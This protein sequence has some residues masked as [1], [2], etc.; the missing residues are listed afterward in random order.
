MSAAAPTA[1]VSY[2]RFALLV[3]A[4]AALLRLLHLAAAMRSPITFNPGPDEDFYLRF[5]GQVA[6]GAPLPIDFLFMDPLYG[7]LAGAL[8]ALA[9][10]SVFALYALQAAVDTLTVYMLYRCGVALSA[11]RA[12][13]V[14][15]A[16]YALSATAILF[17]A[18][19]LKPTWVAAFVVGWTWLALGCLRGASPRRWLM[20]GLLCGLGIALRSNLLLLGAFALAVLP[21]LASSGRTGVRPLAVRTAALGAGLA[22]VLVVLAFNNSRAGLGWTPLP[23]NGGIVLHHLYNVDNPQARSTYPDFVAYRHPLDIWR[24]YRDEAHR[25]LQRA[26]PP[27]EVSAYWRGEALAYIRA[28]PAQFVRNAVRKLGEFIAWPEVP[29]N[30]ILRQE[31]RY[32]AVLAALPSPFGWLLALGVPGLLLLARSDWRAAAVVAAPLLVCAATVMVFFAESR[33]RFHA[34]P[35]LA[36][37]GG[38]LVDRA[39]AWLV[40]RRWREPAIYATV[41]A[42]TGA[43][44][45]VLAHGQAPVHR[46]EASREAWGFARMGDTDRAGALARQAL[47]AGESD[48]AL[49]ELLGFLAARGGQHR[50]A[51]G[52]YAAALALRPDGHATYHSLALSLAALDDTA[53]ALAAIDIALAY[54]DQP[55]YRQL[56]SELQARL[57][58]PGLDPAE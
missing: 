49:H 15:A 35:S 4:A 26:A 53:A 23:F 38:V 44:S 27:A 28:E 51:V 57:A 13:L 41:A 24:G 48:P 56:R 20:L 6:Q 58:A 19:A 30:R 40:A 34:V 42:A 50:E 33:F 11:P 32:S 16:L 39:W 29:N 14:A 21:A 43:L 55:E 7:Y 52:H 31:Q 10:S 22:L 1:A 3:T 47:A 46:N 17:T 9:G 2:G 54:A 8:F 25:R 18:T 36:I 37:A 12:G 45:L 5:A